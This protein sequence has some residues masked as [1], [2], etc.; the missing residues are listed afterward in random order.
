MVQSR[1]QQQALLKDV[2]SIVKISYAGAG[3]NPFTVTI[4]ES[5]VPVTAC[6]TTKEPS[7]SPIARIGAPANGFAG[8]L[9]QVNIAAGGVN[10]VTL[11]C[12]TVDYGV[13]PPTTPN[14]AP[15]GV[16][17][18][19]FGPRNAPSSA[20]VNVDT[21]GTF[22]IDSNGLTYYSGIAGFIQPKSPTCLMDGSDGLLH[23]YFQA[24]NNLL[25][26]A[27]FS[28]LAARASFYA[29]WTTNWGSG[30]V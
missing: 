18:N 20:I 16:T 12:N 23:L 24:S 26:V 4:N 28:T 17:V 13:T 15:S 30:S 7:G 9:N 25:S 1:T 27:Q 14:T 22:H 10:V 8:S 21:S 19:V 11:P 29:N 3:N 2:W 6:T 5:V